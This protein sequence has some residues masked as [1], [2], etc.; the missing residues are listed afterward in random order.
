MTR[1]EPSRPSSLGILVGHGEL[2]QAM[3]QAAVSIVG[4]EDGLIVLSN[5]GLSAR[6]LE[7]RLNQLVDENAEQDILVFVD[8][9]GSSCANVSAKLK[10]RHPRIAVVCGVNLPMLVRFLC[11]RDRLG[12]SELFELVHRTGREEIKPTPG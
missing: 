11:Y 8:L 5:Q 1:S 9:F 6:Q 10:Q 7:E 4:R 12:L 2:P 3:C